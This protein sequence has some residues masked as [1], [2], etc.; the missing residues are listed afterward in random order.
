MGNDEAFAHN[1]EQLIKNDGKKRNDDD[2]FW[3]NDPRNDK[4]D[5]KIPENDIAFIKIRR[6]TYRN[7]DES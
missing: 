3:K 7:G 6:N 2:D 1:D 4:E 5:G